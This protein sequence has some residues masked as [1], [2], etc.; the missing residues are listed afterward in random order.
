M[1]FSALWM[2]L[3]QAALGMGVN[4]YVAIPVVHPGAQAGDYFTGSAR[5]VWWAIEHGGVTLAAHAVLG[6]ALVSMS[7]S[8]VMVAAKARRRAVTAWS[9]LGLLFVLAAGFNGAAFLDYNEALSSLLM[10]LFAFT[11]A[12]CYA[13]ATFTLATPRRAST[14]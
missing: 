9:G 3:A 10:A 5:S 6:I 8:V 1:T 4:L 7:V 14:A 12:G 13:T 11:A 2:V